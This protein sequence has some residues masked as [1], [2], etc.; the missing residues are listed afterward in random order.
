MILIT[1]VILEALVV[2]AREAVL[3][4]PPLEPLDMI[5]FQIQPQSVIIVTVEIISSQKKKDKKYPSLTIHAT[6]IS[7]AKHIR[8]NKV[9]PQKI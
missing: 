3:L 2:F 5:G 6:I 9:N 8:Q 7:V 1:L 4:A